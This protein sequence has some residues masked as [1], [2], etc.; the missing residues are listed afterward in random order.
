MNGAL[1]LP[2]TSPYSRFSRT[3]TMT[4]GAAGAVALAVVVDSVTAVVLVMDVDVDVD[5]AVVAT[6]FFE[7]QATNVSINVTRISLRVMGLTVEPLDA[8]LGARVTGVRLA[9]L[10]DKE[11]A[12]IEDACH[13]HAI[14]VF[15]A[16][17]LEGDEQKAFGRRFGVLEDIG[18]TAG[19]TPISNQRA[20]G[21]LLDREHP[22]SYILRGNEG[23]HTDSSYMPVSAKAS[24]LWAH[25]LPS[26]GG[27][28]EWAGMRAAY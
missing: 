3:M 23:W 17:H 15:P 8:T 1:S 25:V 20:D 22:V 11:W 13:E 4:W 28:P 26:H 9:S 27:T 24:M 7:W 2:M 16:Q 14:L 12:G 18:G 10:S 5:V 6:G 21:S 19:L